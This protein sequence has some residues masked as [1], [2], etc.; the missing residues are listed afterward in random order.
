MKS[1]VTETAKTAG[2]TYIIWAHPRIDSL[3]AQVVDGLKKQ[4][5][6]QQ[7]AVAEL[8]LYRADFDPSLGKEDEP[9][10]LN[11]DKIYSEEVRALFAELADVDNIIVVFP[12]WWYSMP[13]ILKGY[14]DRVWNYGLAYGKGRQL[15]ARSIRW[16]SLVGG[17]KDK[18]ESHRKDEYMN[19][20]LNTI[21]LY[22]GVEDSKV[23]YLYNTIGFEEDI[24]NPGE[25]H[26]Q[27]I[28]QAKA[29]VASL[30]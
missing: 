6:N 22:V 7:M 24:T 16:I 20:L 19:D 17:A 30:A 21:A 12:L 2:K 5:I 10:W 13:A 9:D 8:D 26:K 4:A 18:F 3:T 29:V 28:A 1:N 27:L 14:F 25:H 23:E 11:P 15:S